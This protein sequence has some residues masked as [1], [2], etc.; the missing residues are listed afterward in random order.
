M[1]LKIIFL[2]FLEY[3]NKKYNRSKLSYIIE[4][5]TK[6][7]MGRRKKSDAISVANTSDSSNSSSH[8]SSNLNCMQRKAANDR[9]RTR[10]RVLS[11]A[12]VRLKTSLPWVPSDTKL[13]KLDTLKLASSYIS[14]LTR[15]L[16]TDGCI[17]TEQLMSDASFTNFYQLCQHQSS[18][19]LS[20]VTLSN[21]DTQKT[22]A[23]H[24]SS[25]NLAPFY[26]NQPT[27]DLNNNNQCHDSFKESNNSY[28]SNLNYN[29]YYSSN[30]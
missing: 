24:L 20:C 21:L 18:K 26:Q 9:E 10:M 5:F 25:P 13:S 11:K 7:K 17:D 3:K 19:M 27:Y 29:E 30:L 8:H 15:L 2:F 16:E 4:V 22:I 12:F 23:E 28:V 6:N 14:Y 1:I